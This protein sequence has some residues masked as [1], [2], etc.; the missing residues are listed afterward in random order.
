MTGSSKPATTPVTQTTTNEPWAGAVPA[1]STALG[2]AQQQFNAGAP[3]YFPGNPVAGL[4]APTLQGMGMVQ[5]NAQMTQPLA[6]FGTGFLANTMN[7]AHTPGQG[8][9]GA[10]ASGAGSNPFLS[11]ISGQ[12]NGYN[13][14]MGQVG[15]AATQGNAGLAA[16][17]PFL[18]G[19]AQNPFATQ[20]A[21]SVG[22][23]ASGPGMN[24]LTTA[25]TGGMMQNPFLDAAV[26]RAT[27]SVRQNVGALFAKGGRYGSA[28]HQDTLQTGVGD[29]ASSMYGAAYDQDMTRRL[30]AAGQL[31]GYENAGLDRGLSALTTA[32]QFGE[33]AL[34]RQYDAATLMPAYFEQGATRAMTGLGAEADSWNASRGLNLQ[35]MGLGADVFGGDVN[36]ALDAFGA[37]GSQQNAQ[38]GLG[39]TAA[40]MLPGMYD[41]SNQGAYNLMDVGTQLENFDQANIDAQ[42]AAWDYNQ[43][44]QRANIEW[45]NAIATG[46][47]QLGGVSTMV[48]QQPYQRGSTLGAIGGA[49]AG[50]GG[51]MQGLG[52]LGVTF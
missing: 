24:T 28:A 19:G 23:G 7:G 34:G 48:G 52:A 3:A 2:A 8:F 21:A 12:T 22:Q 40:G 39:L 35:A 49:A 31:A 14:F 5:Q 51:L 30:G 15:A 42:R 1:L 18:S 10:I 29:V 33:S 17:N 13:P 44:A 46:A 16:L 36:R 38:A 4:S 32:G 37:V 25:A 11:S 41:F 47:G 26:G 9:A 50:I 43:N 27:D 6:A 45:L 20:I